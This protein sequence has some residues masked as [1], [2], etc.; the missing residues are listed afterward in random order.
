MSRTSNQSSGLKN[1][2]TKYLNWKSS[3]KAFTFWNKQA[4]KEEIVD[5]RS[6]SFVVLDQLNTIKGFD[7]KAMSGLWSNEVRSVGKDELSVKNKDGLVVKG[8]YKDIKGKHDGKF[9]K[10]VYV[11]GKIGDGD[12]ELIN[13]QF[14][15]AS[16]S[17]WFTFCESVG[18]VET[19]I[20]ISATNVAEA[21]KGSVTYCF[22]EFSVVS[23]Q[24]SEA[25]AEKANEADET[26]QAYL[27][28]Y[29]GS[30]PEASPASE[31]AEETV[32]A[33]EEPWESAS[34]F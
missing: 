30:E 6:L 2:A 31:P 33:A 11:L 21:K 27:K 22:P 15:G 7:E 17:S 25:T 34:P 20:A 1:P 26:L 5:P 24:I 16:L 28:T 12:H 4:E 19:D 18:N 3:A 23:N 14:S 10:S 9:T 8:L 13:L 29:F 32:P